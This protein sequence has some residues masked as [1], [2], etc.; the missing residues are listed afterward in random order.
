[1]ITKLDRSH[2]NVL[3]FAVSGDVT[4]AD[5]DVL[6]PAVESAL[7]HADSVRLLLDLTEFHWEKVEAWGADLGFGHE[8]RHRIARMAIVGD[9]AWEKYLAHLAQPFYAEDT[10]FFQDIDQAWS[11]VAAGASS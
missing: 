3:G 6:T 5:Y 1:M 11:W 8:F 4:K 9:K 2:D 10:A 7:T